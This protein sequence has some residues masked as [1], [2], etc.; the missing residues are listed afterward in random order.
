[1]RIQSHVALKIFENSILKFYCQSLGE[2]LFVQW[3]QKKHSISLVALE[4]DN[5]HLVETKSSFE[6]S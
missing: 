3:K 2:K 5:A 1:M 6:L 4:D